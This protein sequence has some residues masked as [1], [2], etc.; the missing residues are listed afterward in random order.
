MKR[1]NAAALTLAA[2]VVLAG[3]G[4]SD[5]KGT[6][7]PEPSGSSSAGALPDLSGETLEVAAEWQ[8]DEQKNFEAVL[9]GFEDQTGAQI[10]Y[11]S[12]GSDTA[13][14]LGTRVEGGNPPDVALIPQPGLIQQ[15]VDKG[16][17][18]PLP[19]AVSDA[20]SA[21]FGPAW[22]DLGTFDGK[23]YAVWFKGA[24]KSTMWYRPDTFEQAGIDPPSTWDDFVTSL[25]TLRDSGT[26]PLSVGGGD[27]WTL[28]DWFENVY[29][30]S[31]GPDMYDQL[32]THDIKWTDQSVKDALTMLSKAWTKEFIAPNALQT[33]FPDSVTQVFGTKK[34]AQVYEGDFVGGVITD[35]TKA[36]VGTDALFYPFPQA[37]DTVG[38]VGGG[39]A[40]VMFNDSEAA[41]ALIQYLASPEAASI[42]VKLGGFTSPNKNVAPA[43]YPDDISRQLAEQLV[44]AEAFKFDMS[45]QTP[46]QF[47]GT[48]GQ[49]EW[50]DLQ[51]LLGGASVDKTAKSLE[52]HAAAAY[53]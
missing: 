51:D 16:A 29:L 42:W 27:G 32:T 3:C 5:D 46:S 22:Q 50:K 31:A 45:D 20:V 19:S 15:F 9:Q 36:K 41:A 8:K 13:T 47:G 2:A 33:L 37:G 34:A 49:G 4:G 53:K 38:V 39:D 28:T 11:T 12:T 35:S 48:P 23:L 21:N 26:T 18:K 52:K 14:I 17:V 1:L 7:T 25:Q 30:S 40:A 43:D 6:D 44:N 24:N 10:K